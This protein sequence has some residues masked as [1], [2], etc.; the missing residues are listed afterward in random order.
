MSGGDFTIDAL[1]IAQKVY[2][3]LN[4]IAVSGGTYD[5]WMS[6]VYTHERVKG[7]ESPVYHGS[8]I[9][10]L[11]FQEVISN[12]ATEEDPLGTLAG[13]GRLTAKHK[14]GIINIKVNEPSIIMG[15]VSIT[16]RIEYSQGNDWTVNL[17]TFDDLHKP[18]LDGIGFQDLVTE[19]MLWS[20]TSCDSATGAITTKS[21]RDWETDRKSVV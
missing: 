12:A 3:M 8:L 18:G 4:R 2:V 13:R 6:A 10:E 9:K 21:Y 1:N 5:D 15:I 19:Q 20:D 7:I 16:P 11:A 17:K 14:G